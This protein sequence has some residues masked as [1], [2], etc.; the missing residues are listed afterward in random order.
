MKYYDYAYYLDA[1]TVSKEYLEKEREQLRYTSTHISNVQTAW[2]MIKMCPSIRSYISELIKN[3]IIPCN[4]IYTDGFIHM[5]DIQISLHDKSKYGP[6]EW[7][8]YRKYFYPINDKEKEGNKDD[9]DAAWLHH[10]TVNKHHW[11]YWYK[12]YKDVDAMDLLSVVE[13]CCDWIAMNFV[14][15]GT[16]L[17]FY[18]N[19]VE[20]CK[21]KDEQIYLG[22]KQKVIIKKILEMFYEEYPKIEE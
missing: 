22:E 11:D 19:R 10:Y 15:K 3:K 17:D 6:E 20:K 8:P 16:A 21:D 2:S 7:E 18:K 13:L 5:M 9:F 12:I 4:Y 14:F 1:N